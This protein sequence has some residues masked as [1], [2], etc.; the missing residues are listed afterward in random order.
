VLLYYFFKNKQMKKIWIFCL[1]LLPFW[2]KAQ[3]KIGLGNRNSTEN[4]T[5]TGIDYKNPKEYQIADITVSGIEGLSPATIISMSGLSKGSTIKIPGEGITNAIKKIWKPGLVGDVQIWVTKIEG[6]QVF[7]EIRLKERARLSRFEFRGISKGQAQ[8]LREKISLIRGRMIN[9]ATLKNTENTIRKY[10][11]DKGFRNVSVNILQKKDTLTAGN[12]VYL[13]INV[14]RNKKVKINDI[15]FEGDLTVKESVLRRKLKKTKERRFGRIFSPSKYLDAE[16][17]SDRGN[18]ITF[19]NQQGYRN[20]Q[21]EEWEVSNHDDQ[22]VNIRMKINEGKKFYYRNIHWTGNFVYTSEQLDKVLGIAKGDVYN[23]EELSKRL[24]FSQ[25]SSDITSLYMDDGYL[26][27]NIQP[28]EVN[29]S[30]DSIDIEMRIFEGEQAN[31]N[32]VIIQGNTITSDHVIRRELR[33]IPGEK[34]SRSVL[35][36]TRQELST[37]GYFNPETIDM[38]PV[39]NQSDGTVDII[40]KLEEK[41]SNTFELSG[42]WGGLQG[43]VGTLGLTINN[44]ALSKVFQKGAWQPIP[45]GN[46][47]KLSLRFQSN[48]RF[49][50]NYSLSFTEPWLGGKKPHSFSFS[51][52]HSITSNF[53]YYGGSGG[54]LQITGANLSL[55]RR[56]TFPDDFFTMINTFS[57]Q[58]YYLQDYQ[59]FLSNFNNGVSNNF[60]FNTTI[61]RNSVDNPTYPRSGSNLSLSVSLT[62]P[63]SLLFNRSITRDVNVIERLRLIEYH[64]WMFDNSWYLKLAGNLVL[65]TGVHMGF[66]GTYKKGNDISPFERFVMGGSG[67]TINNFLLG[68]DIVALRGYNDNSI[69]ALDFSNGTQEQLGGTIYNKFVFELR[70]P[71]SLQPSATIFLLAFAEGGNVWGN[72]QDF[73]P[74]DIKRSVGVGA[75][76]FMPMFGMLGFD[77]GYGFDQVAGNPNVN[78]GQF[79]FTIGQQI[80]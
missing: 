64:K 28:I 39:P 71:V 3:V 54:S 68:Q 35:I 77:Y 20:A 16:F 76:I 75:R 2:A 22:S 17:E 30:E 25:T 41:S 19:Y 34:F 37:L 33:T 15:V 73:N 79:H 57:Y 55:G 48:G 52:N 5:S 70:Y 13:E 23:P 26:F 65:R 10:Y 74:F 4:T 78:G 46:G 43:F 49:F 63:Y 7:L 42:G 47:Q 62:P 80:R 12:W 67:M 32:K 18:L 9:D 60:N 44:F 61:S 59:F 6:N 29:V 31:I 27:F 66:M 11:A 72:Y 1:L 40:Y 24:N 14:N 53:N 51:V 38:Q 45:Q 56:L 8:T 50:Q 21:V 69:K 36:R 58:R